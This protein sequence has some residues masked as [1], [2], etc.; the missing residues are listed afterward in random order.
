MLKHSIFP[1]K[2]SF[3]N[4]TN[5]QR[6]KETISVYKLYINFIIHNIMMYDG[7]FIFF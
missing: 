4:Y 1:K 2:E 5:K 3:P 6:K 7:K